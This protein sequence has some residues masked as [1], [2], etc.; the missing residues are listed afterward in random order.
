VKAEMPKPEEPVDSLPQNHYIAYSNQRPR[1]SAPKQ[2]KD[3]EDKGSDESDEDEEMP[4][5]RLPTG[6]TVK[7]TDCV[8]SR[9]SQLRNKDRPRAEAHLHQGCNLIHDMMQAYEKDWYAKSESMSY[10]TQFPGRAAVCT[11]PSN[12]A[13]ITYFTERNKQKVLEEGHHV[14]NDDRA[15]SLGLQKMDCKEVFRTKEYCCD[16]M[17]FLDKV[18]EEQAE[19]TAGR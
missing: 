3:E 17:I 5:W 10:E 8:T 6:N 4:H 1:R 19:I 15:P 16:L 2:E 7:L 13:A 18:F 12:P 11:F 9:C 14:R